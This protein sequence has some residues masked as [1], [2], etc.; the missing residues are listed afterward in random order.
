MSYLRDGLLQRGFV[1]ILLNG[2]HVLA[3]ADLPLIHRDPFDRVLLAQALVENITLATVD[4]TLA[5]YDVPM[6]YVG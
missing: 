5:A 3:T 4:K 6:L 2:P 1:E